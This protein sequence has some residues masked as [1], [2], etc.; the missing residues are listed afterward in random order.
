MIKLLTAAL[1]LSASSIQT[2]A[3][4]PTTA[5]PV[6]PLPGVWRADDGSM[7]VKFANCL[8]GTTES[9]GFCGTVLEEKIQPDA[10]PFLGKVI[11]RDMVATGKQSWEGKYLGEKKPLTAKAKLASANKL[12][13]RVCL[14]AFVCENLSFSRVSGAQ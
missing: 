2:L 12:S 8:V 11:I 7:T 1:L 10:V 4:T 13:F 6:D 5:A 9:K 3:Q 14:V